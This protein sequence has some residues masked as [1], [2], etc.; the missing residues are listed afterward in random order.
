VLTEHLDSGNARII[1]SVWPQFSSTVSDCLLCICSIF[2]NM[3]TFCFSGREQIIWVGVCSLLLGEFSTCDKLQP[4]SSDN[5]MLTNTVHSL[6]AWNCYLI[7]WFD[8]AS[9]YLVRI[10]VSLS[11]SFVYIIFPINQSNFLLF[12]FILMYFVH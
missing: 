12:L 10:S 1:A 9:N 11:L 5:F 8:T 4:I 2:S 6:I 7:L 3:F